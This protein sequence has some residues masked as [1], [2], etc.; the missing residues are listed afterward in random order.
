MKKLNYLQILY[1]IGIL[2]VVFG[3][4][5]H[6]NRLDI[7]KYFFGA[8]SVLII[9]ERLIVQFQTK[10]ADF[11]AQRIG[12]M[13]LMMSLLLGLG[14]YSMFDGTTLWIATIVIYALVTL[15]LSFRS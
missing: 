9:L 13:Q 3:S 14:T 5:G 2:L 11:K 4:L 15:F 1:V 12:R 10:E 6:F 8:G 7:A